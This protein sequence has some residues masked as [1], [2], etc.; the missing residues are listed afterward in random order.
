MVLIVAVVGFFLVA[1]ITIPLLLGWAASIFRPLEAM[2]RTISRVEAGEMEA[3][4]GMTE[5]GDEIGRLAYHFDGL[6]ALVQQRDAQLRSWADELDR[7]VVE[8]TCELQAANEE[9]AATQRRL[10]MS[11]KLASIGEITA[12]VAHE[13]NNPVAVI[14]GNLDV[15]RDVLGRPRHRSAPSST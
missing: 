12:G 8:R 9:L 4:T 15:A 6:L 1:L 5:T 3:R 10:V 2:D 13:I 14:Q 7:R 11:E